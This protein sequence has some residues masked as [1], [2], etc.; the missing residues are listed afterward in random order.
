MDVARSRLLQLTAP[1][2]ILG[3]KILSTI[4]SFSSREIFLSCDVN[5]TGRADAAKTFELVLHDKIG[6]VYVS[7]YPH[8]SPF[9]CR[10]TLCVS[11][12]LPVLWYPSVSRQ[13]KISSKFLCHVAPSFQFA[14]KRR[15]AIAKGASS[16]RTFNRGW[17]GKIRNV[18]PTR[19]I[20]Q[21]V[22]Y[23]PVVAVER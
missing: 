5:D 16:A 18:R 14:P 10:A 7:L 4:S 1:L 17:V 13:L 11:A 8:V 9:F 6:A 2:N 15:H 19:D 23:R 12:V 22:R 20:L 3:N 21:M